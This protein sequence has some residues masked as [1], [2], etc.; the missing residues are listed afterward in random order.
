[1][2]QDIYEYCPTYDQ[3]QITNNMLTKNLAKLV[4]TLLEETFQKWGLD[5]IGL[6]KLASRLS[7]N[8][9][10]LVATDYVAKWVEA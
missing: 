2:N 4:T 8:R 10:I 5:F 6:V 9:Y 3:C 7:N 1:M